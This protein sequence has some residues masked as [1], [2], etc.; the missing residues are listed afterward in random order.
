MRHEAHA[1]TISDEAVLFRSLRPDFIEMTTY[2]GGRTP[3][4]AGLFRSLRPDFIETDITSFMEFTE[5]RLFRSL[6][7]D[8]IETKSHMLKTLQETKIVPVSKTGLH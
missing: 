6:R 4:L 7:P 5:D 3:G 2:G 8:L 1:M